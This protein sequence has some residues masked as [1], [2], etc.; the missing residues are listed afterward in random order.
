MG[1]DDKKNDGTNNNKLDLKKELKSLK[2]EQA[3]WTQEPTIFDKLPAH[4][5]PFSIEPLPN[6]RQ[7]IP[8]KMSDEDRM[9]R[10]IYLESQ[11]LTDREPI[12]VPELE[13]QLYNPFRRLYRAPTDKLFK[14]LGPLLGEHRVPL[15]R[16]VVPKLFMGY[17]AGCVLWYN[18]KYNN[19]VSSFLSLIHIYFGSIFGSTTKKIRI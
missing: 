3:K 9:R 10:K 11:A 14:A 5:K 18:L 6:E 16:F 15:Y 4:E 13:R 2:V 8:F 12:R 19:P 17:L 7:R 1:A